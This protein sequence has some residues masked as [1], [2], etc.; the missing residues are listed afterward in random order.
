MPMHEISL[1][2]NIRE[3]L[4]DQAA[5]DGYTRVNKVWLEI[6]P[7]SCVEPGALRFGFDVVMRGSVAEGAELE[8]VTPPAQ[9]RCLACGAVAAVT[10]RYEICSS[11][12]S[13]GMELTQ[14]D[15]LRISRLEVV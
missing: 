15:E 1:C 7:L 14:G 8:I 12:G 2:G 3:I 13:P 10:Q 4:E 11:C 6:G 9:A 5:K